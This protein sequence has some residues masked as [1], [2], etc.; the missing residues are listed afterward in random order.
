MNAIARKMPGDRYRF[1]RPS[2]SRN[3]KANRQER[4]VIDALVAACFVHTM[5]TEGI[6]SVYEQRGLVTLSL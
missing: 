4:R 3:T 2:T 6:D 1:D 5:A